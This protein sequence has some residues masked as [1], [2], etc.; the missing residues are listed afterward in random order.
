MVAGHPL[1]M[2]TRICWACKV[3]SHMTTHGPPNIVDRPR[4][5]A[6]LVQQGYVC[7][8]CRCLSIGSKATRQSLDHMSPNGWQ[9]WIEEQ[10][11]LHWY[12]EVGVG[13]DF[14][15]VPRHIADAASEAFECQSINAHRAAISLAR[16]VIEATAKEK[17][18][19]KGR[20]VDKI[21][22]MKEEGFVRELVKEA[23]HEV[24]HLGN[25]MAHGDF[26]EPVTKEEAEEILGLTSEVLAEVFQAPAQVAARKAAR[27]AKSAEAPPSN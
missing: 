6:T 13:R 18:I 20:L 3:K 11:D 15:D 10:G 8:S 2:A 17:G 12:P 22:A 5:Q 16:S 7:D 27:L 1:R 19:T 25:D 9:E 14:P 23:A 26:V 21:D 4:G 24:R